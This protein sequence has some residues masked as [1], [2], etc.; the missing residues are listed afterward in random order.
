MR[1]ARV[2]YEGE[3][4]KV[5]WRGTTNLYN[6]EAEAALDVGRDGV[7]EARLLLG[8]QDLSDA[9]IRHHLLLLV[10]GDPQEV[11][12]E[13][14]DHHLCRQSVLTEGKSG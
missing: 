9:F 4:I 6:R 8:L 1:Q 12:R 13:F 14:P 5:T 3:N 7:H 2:S 10:V 11:S